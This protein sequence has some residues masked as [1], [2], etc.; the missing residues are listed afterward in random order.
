MQQKLTNV[1]F[2]HVNEHAQDEFTNFDYTPPNPRYPLSANFIYY[3]KEEYS[4][5]QV[6]TRSSIAHV[7]A[8]GSSLDGT[9]SRKDSLGTL[10]NPNGGIESAPVK[11]IRI[12]SRVQSKS[13]PKG[14]KFSI[15]IMQ[16]YC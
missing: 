5:W 15:L 1:S 14:G 8:V 10:P 16:E 11:K 9:F 7:D 4:V 6:G 3:L 2:Q 13:T 12:S